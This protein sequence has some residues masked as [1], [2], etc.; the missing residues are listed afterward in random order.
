LFFPKPSKSVMAHF[1][2]E[3]RDTPAWT[4]WQNDRRHKF[5]INDNGKLYSV[6]QIVSMATNAALSAFGRGKWLP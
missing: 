5:A 1:D 4:N 3:L 6:K 2:V